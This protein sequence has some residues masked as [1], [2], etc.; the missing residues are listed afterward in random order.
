M[1]ILF[2]RL[3]LV[4]TQTISFGPFLLIVLFLK[5]HPRPCVLNAGLVALCCTCSCFVLTFA[6]LLVVVLLLV[7]ELD[8]LSVH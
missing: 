2:L 7:T 8:T 5:P 6:H 4:F 1:I 3:M